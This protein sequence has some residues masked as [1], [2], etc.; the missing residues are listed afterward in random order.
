MSVEVQDD[1]IDGVRLLQVRHSVTTLR[2]KYRL[3]RW[4]Q[5][6]GR[7]SS[8]VTLPPTHPEHRKQKQGDGARL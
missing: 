8:K 3:W 6:A 2:R 1:G 7:I 5:R 4:W